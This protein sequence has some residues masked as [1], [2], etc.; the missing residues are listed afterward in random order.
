MFWNRR[1]TVFL[2]LLLLVSTFVVVSHHHA[3]MADD[4]DCPICIAGNQLSATS[5]LSVTFDI[6][7]CFTEITVVAP[8]PVSIDNF[9]SHSL[10]N[11]APPA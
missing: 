4:H 11:R 5:H 1:I 9:L 10:S 6:V 2:I 3:D 7:P 8:S